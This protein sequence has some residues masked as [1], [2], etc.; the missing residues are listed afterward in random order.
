[1]NGPRVP[2]TPDTLAPIDHFHGKGA[3]A[4]E[5]IA[6]KLQPK[7]SDHVLNIGCGIGEPAPPQTTSAALPEWI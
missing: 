4:T 5:E 2:I 3:I 6:A 1:M 7:P